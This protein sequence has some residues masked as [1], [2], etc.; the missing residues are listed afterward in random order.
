[1]RLINSPYKEKLERKKN[2]GASLLGGLL[3]YFQSSTALTMF[4]C[5]FAPAHGVVATYHA[6]SKGLN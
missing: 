5:L 6:S 3:F 2:V 1:M 4:C